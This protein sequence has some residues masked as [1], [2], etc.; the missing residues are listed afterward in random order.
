MQIIDSRHESPDDYSITVV[1]LG[2]ERWPGDPV[3][4][5]LSV[6]LKPEAYRRSRFEGSSRETKKHGARRLII[7]HDELQKMVEAL[8]DELTLCYQVLNEH[9]LLSKL[10][11]AKKNRAIESSGST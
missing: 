3:S 6:S 4:T 9:H 1:Q 5:Y 8:R 11:D 10:H 2:W 7:T